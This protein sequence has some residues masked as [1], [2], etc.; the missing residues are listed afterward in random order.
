MSLPVPQDPAGAWTGVHL[1]ERTATW[2]ERDAILYALSVGAHAD[3]LDLV[4]ERRLRVL[5]TFGLTLAQWAPDV[6][7]ANGA[8]EQSTALHGSQRLEV[9]AP[10]PPSGELTLSSRVSA[11]W[12]KGSAAVFDIEV[13]SRC[14]T[15]TW[16]I[17]APG[18]GG[19]GGDRGPSTPRPAPS[20]EPPLT[21]DIPTSPDQAAL[22]R[23]SGDLHPLHI[24]PEAA[25]TAGFDHPIL[26]GLATLAT[27]TVGLAR[28][29]GAHP[30]DLHSTSARFTAP[31]TPG[32]PLTLT[33]HRTPEGAT[34]TALIADRPVLSSAT[35]TF[36]P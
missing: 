25:R 4:Y 33:A 34:Y 35:A 28:A 11:V 36:T 19:F 5:P 7:G 12:D 20:P 18:R 23:L 10:L 13:E 6:A 21:I 24:D 9:S 16:T 2:T 22:Y 29:L 30:A 31:V 3:D 1:G 17:F 32:D 26:H 27:T 14:F 15:A 8:F